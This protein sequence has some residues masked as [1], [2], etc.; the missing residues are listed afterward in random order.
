MKELLLVC[1]LKEELDYFLNEIKKKDSGFYS[2]LDGAGESYS[3]YSTEEN[4]LLGRLVCAMGQGN[5]KI[6]ECIDNVKNK[7]NLDVAILFGIAAGVKSKVKLMDIIVTSTVWDL[8]ICTL[9]SYLFEPWGIQSYKNILLF[10]KTD[11]LLKKIKK[12]NESSRIFDDL[13]CGGSDNL[14]RD[15]KYMEMASLTH[16][17]LGMIEMESVGT[18]IGCS[19]Y[20]IPFIIIKSITDYGDNNK[21][22]EIHKTCCKLVSMTIFEGI[23]KPYLKIQKERKQTEPSFVM[24]PGTAVLTSITSTTGG[25]TMWTPT[26]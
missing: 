25:S 14:I 20:N 18:A 5:T 4:L 13:I 16:K 9:D 2:K 17:K 7:E 15:E 12:I 11:E 19:D 22:D 1:A 6:K 10:S 3:I 26:G 21:D 24:T 23:L 8:R